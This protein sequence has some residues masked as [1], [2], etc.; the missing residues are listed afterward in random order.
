MKSKREKITYLTYASMIAA[1][2]VILTWMSDILGLAYLTPQI[3]LGEA[4]CVLTWFTPAAVPGLFI[5]C[6]ISNLTMGCVVWDVIFGSLA[7]LIGAFFGF[8]MK[9]K[10]LVPLPTVISNT[11]VVPFIILYC[12]MDG[13]GLEL[14]TVTAIG[15]FAGEVLSAY[16]IGLILLYAVDKRN[17]FRKK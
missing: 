11:V 14:Y 5:G 1:L 16:V 3:R 4:L 9:R 10:W 12:Y 6:I 17:I 13:V 8:K 15:V 7:T 2:Y